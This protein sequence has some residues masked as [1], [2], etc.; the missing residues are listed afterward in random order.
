MFRERGPQGHLWKLGGKTI[1]QVDSYKYLGIVVKP[2]LRWDKF[3][4]RL[5][6]KAKKALVISWAMGIRS[7]H[8]TVTAALNIWNTLVRPHLEYGWK[9]WDPEKWEDAEKLQRKMGRRIL[10]V[11]QNVNNEVVYGELGWWTLKTRRDMLRLRYWKKLLNMEETRLT[12]IVYIWE[13]T[14]NLPQSWCAHTRKL[15]VELGL[16]DCWENQDML[17]LPA[18]WNTIIW[19]KL[20]KREEDNWKRIMANKPRLRTYRRFKQELV[21]E[22][23]LK[24]KDQ[25][26]R[27]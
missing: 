15:L 2:N 8:L 27:R 1:Q 17:D 23:Y 16:G 10:G 5:L 14:L 22:E 25:R 19:D 18:G 12:K 9:I 20:Q 26:G 21:L 3:K 13:K 7:G 24:A 6:E 4:H 11:R